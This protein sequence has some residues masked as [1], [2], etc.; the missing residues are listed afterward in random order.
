MRVVKI[1]SDFVFAA[2]IKEQTTQYRRPR[3]FQ[4]VE[5]RPRNPVY[6]KSM[7]PRRGMNTGSRSVTELI[8]DS[9]EITPRG[10]YNSCPCLHCPVI[11]YRAKHAEHSQRC[12]HVIIYDTRAMPSETRGTHSLWQVEGTQRPRPG[13]FQ[14]T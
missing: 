1:S 3:Y 5:T 13:E 10:K 4:A 12:V 2:E 6:Q 7:Q 9:H 11:Y 8:I 14:G